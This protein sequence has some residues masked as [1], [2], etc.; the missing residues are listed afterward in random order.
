VKVSPQLSPSSS[1]QTPSPKPPAKR[2]LAPLFILSILTAALI[3]GGAYEGVNLAGGGLWPAHA[4]HDDVSAA[5]QQARAEAF[6][7]LPPLSL[8]TV[9][10]RDLDTATR[11]M[12]LPERQR[13]ALIA[14]VNPSP[15][16]PPAV[17]VQPK[18]Q[19]KPTPEPERVRLAWI[20]LWDTDAQDGDVVRIES[21][22]YARTVTLAK[23]P[24]TFAIPVSASGVVRVVGVHDGDGGGI[25]VGLASG[26]SKAV[27]PVMTEEQVLGLRVAIN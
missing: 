16:A 7:A 8:Q 27:F 2:R 9:G 18:V 21:Q 13:Q 5:D 26:A 12:G 23:A 3:A 1:L 14:Q 19:P 11:G 20:T 25:T 4:G 10:D 17:A 6:A 22:G 24:L 15:S